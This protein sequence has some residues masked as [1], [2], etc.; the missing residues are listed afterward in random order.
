M[1]KLNITIWEISTNSKNKN[2]DELEEIIDDK[3]RTCKS[4]GITI[5]TEHGCQCRKN[6][7]IL[8]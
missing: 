7:L 5:F 6:D 1:N 2:K 8:T 3:W 4:C